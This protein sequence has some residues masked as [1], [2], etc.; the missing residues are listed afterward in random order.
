LEH[1]IYLYS[2]IIGCTLVGIQVILQVFGLFDDVDTDVDGHVEVDVSDTH[3]DAA[4]AHVEADTDHHGSSAFF[5]I[6]SFRALCAFAGIFGLIGLMMEQGGTA[7]RPT[8]VLVA[9][10]A[11]VAAMFGVAWM[12]RALSRLQA[13]GSVEPR[14]AVGRV[15]TVYLRIPAHGD[16][17]GKVTIEIQGRSME[18]PALSEGDEIQTGARVTVVA[19]E[20]DD[21]LKVVPL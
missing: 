11:G 7:S 5:G 13:S 18:F 19:L 21:T 20:G 12:M 6:L 2:A 15:G 1:S 14:N 9:C 8:R 4:D 3:L 16:G 10:G 17:A